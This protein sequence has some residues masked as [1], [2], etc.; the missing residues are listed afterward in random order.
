M[1]LNPPRHQSHPGGAGGD[2]AQ[3]RGRIEAYQGLHHPGSGGVGQ[4]DVVLAE[5]AGDALDP[6][7][8]VARRQDA[9]RR[10]GIAVDVGGDHDVAPQLVVGGAQ[11]HDRGMAMPVARIAAALGWDR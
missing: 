10:Q 3:R 8:A 2:V 6:L 5:Q 7:E 4:G 1:A 11:A 9:R